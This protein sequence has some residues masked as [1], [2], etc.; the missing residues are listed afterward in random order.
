[1]TIIPNTP[2]CPTVAAN[3][4]KKKMLKT[5]NSFLLLALTEK[6]WI[7]DRF[8]GAVVYYKRRTL[9][10]EYLASFKRD[11]YTSEEVIHTAFE[12]ATAELKDKNWIAHHRV[13]H[14][15]N[16]Y[17]RQVED[18]LIL[19]WNENTDIDKCALYMAD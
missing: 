10:E 3:Q 12:L 8:D 14:A 19:C 16:G 18:A 1:M 6:P 17:V 13:L 7:F 11:G 5:A 15:D 2:D 9:S 4:L